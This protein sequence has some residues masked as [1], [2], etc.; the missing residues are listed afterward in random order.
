MSLKGKKRE[1]PRP[2]FVLRKGRKEG[3]VVM[4][5]R[6]DEG[7]LGPVNEG[8]E[9][10]LKDLKED[11]IDTL[12]HELSEREVSREMEKAKQ[13]SSGSAL[14]RY[15]EG[16]EF[17]VPVRHLAVSHDTKSGLIKGDSFK[18]LQPNE[19]EEFIWKTGTLSANYPRGS[20]F[21]DKGNSIINIAKRAKT[22]EE[23]RSIAEQFR[24][25]KAEMRG[26]VPEHFMI[27]ADRNIA[28]A[29]ALMMMAP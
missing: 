16:S 18:Q 29:E 17:Q 27:S 19:F 22:K 21:K 11:P 10:R 24:A 12:T 5:E 25:L 4:Y 26:Y 23:Y 6:D 14:W 15:S 9:F 1:N 3:H 28:H 7:S 8:M 13:G 2:S 20:F